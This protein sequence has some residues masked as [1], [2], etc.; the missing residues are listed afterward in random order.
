M[1]MHDAVEDTPNLAG[2]FRPGLSALRA[3]D[4]LHIAL[5]D[6]RNLTGSV[7]VDLALRRVEPQAHRWDFAI[8]YQHTNR[9]AECV[10]WVEIHT[11]SDREVDVVLDKLRWSKQWLG[12]SGKRLARASSSTPF[13]GDPR[14]DHGDCSAEEG[15]RYL[16]S[17]DATGP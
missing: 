6:T 2:A 13:A 9:E 15:R 14:P 8:G 5:E 7:D 11:A 12:R 16:S 10:Y 1:T 17:F 3:Q 4:R